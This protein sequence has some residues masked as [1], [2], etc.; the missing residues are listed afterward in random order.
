MRK[1]IGWLISFL[2]VYFIA[3]YLYALTEPVEEAVTPQQKYE[4]CIAAFAG[5]L[6]RIPEC[7]KYL[8][9]E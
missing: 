4:R 5:N 3:S 9:K 1:S 8:P 2:V 6:E 7:D